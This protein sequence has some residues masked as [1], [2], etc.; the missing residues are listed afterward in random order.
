[1][2]TRKIVSSR[3]AVSSAL[4][5]VLLAG[6]NKPPAYN[7]PKM[8]LAPSWSGEGVFKVATPQDGVLRKDW[9][10]LFGD[11]KLNQLETEAAAANPDLKA[12]AEHYTQ[13][14]YLTTKAESG[15]VPP[16]R[17]GSG[18]Q[19]EQEL[20]GDALPVTVQPHVRYRRNVRR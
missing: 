14:R 11:P 15:T 9:W 19:P 3:I 6:C 4:S 5:L 20:T 18:C 12:A 7:P 1:M 2:R 16:S 10:S 17:P 8:A 13:A